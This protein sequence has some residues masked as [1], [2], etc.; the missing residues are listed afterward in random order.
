LH[1]L[2]FQQAKHLQ[3]KI[4]N[5]K[6]TDDLREKY[7][8]SQDENLYF[9]NAKYYTIISKLNS[10]HKLEI[11]G[12]YDRKKVSLKYAGPVSMGIH[13]AGMSGGAMYFFA[14]KQELKDDIDS[15][16]RFAGIGI[17]YKKDNTIVGVP[18]PKIISL[19]ENLNSEHPLTITIDTITTTP[20]QEIEK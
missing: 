4:H 19:L 3:K 7:V 14:K 12:K 2:D 20:P 6:S 1:G 10:F 9:T 17:G 13:P 8:T 5:S 18:Q 11:T 16:F 15:T